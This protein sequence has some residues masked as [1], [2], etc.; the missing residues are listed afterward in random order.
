MQKSEWK[1]F[2]HFFSHQ[3]LVLLPHTITKPQLNFFS[4]HQLQFAT[5]GL[6]KPRF[7]NH[8]YFFIKRILI[9]GF[10]L[11]VLQNFYLDSMIEIFQRQIIN[12]HDAILFD[13][14]WVACINYQR[15]QIEFYYRRSGGRRKAFGIMWN[16]FWALA[17]YHP[18]KINF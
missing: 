15:I 4:Q 14:I 5:S 13:I 6:T 8:E 7:G 18:N 16:S 1:I 9:R 11:F 17:L 10:Y 3:T 2:V 12:F